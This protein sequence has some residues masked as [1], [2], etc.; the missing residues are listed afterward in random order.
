MDRNGVTLQ[1]YA[2]IVYALQSNYALRHVPFPTFDL[3][4]FV[5]TQPDKVDA[6]VHR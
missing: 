3:Q 2:D 5:K 6:V 4:P 1:G